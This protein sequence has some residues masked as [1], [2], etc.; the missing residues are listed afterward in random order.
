L[1]YCEL[2]SR[3][4]NAEFEIPDFEVLYRRAGAD[5]WGVAP[6]D[7]ARAVAASAA[8]VFRDSDPAPRELARL[9]ESLHVEDLALAVACAAGSEAAWEHFVREFR[10][11]L[12]RSADAIEPGGGARDLADSLYA[13]LYGL[14]ERDGQRRSLFRYYHGRSRLATWLRAVLA[15]RHVDRIRAQRRIDP[16]P[17]ENDEQAAAASPPPDPDRRRLLATI[18]KALAAVLSALSARDR[19]RLSCYYAQEMTLAEVGRVTGEHEATVSRQL[20]RTRR[21]IRANLECHL[22]DQARLSDAEI[23]QGFQYAMENA[24]PIDLTEILDDT[25]ERKESAARRSI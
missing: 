9:V 3:I 24:G 17:D 20:T 6:D 15:Q 21:A 8:S 23:T 1:E 4:P 13:D 12:Y 22:R 10:P 19:L 5:R 14:N 11:V 25:R 2:M 18:K 7:F 16:L